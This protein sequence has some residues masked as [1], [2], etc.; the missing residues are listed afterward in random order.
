MNDVA[1][2]ELWPDLPLD[3]W[4]DTCRT[5]HLWTQIVGKVRIAQTP[6]I[7]H[8]WHVPLYLSARGLTTLVIPT[9]RGAL[10]LEFDL[11]NDRLEVRTSWGG[12]KSVALRAA[13]IADFH[14][15][16]METLKGFGLAIDIHG[17][18]N[19]LEDATPFAAD[20]RP[21][22]Y[23]AE[24]ARRFWRALISAERVFQRFRSSF[25]G[26]CSPIHFFWGSFDLAVTR[27]SGRTAPVHQGGIPNLPDWVAREA[28]S[29]EVSSAGFWPGGGPHPFPLFY[30]YAYPQ[31]DGFA[32]ADPGADQAFF[33]TELGEFVLPYEAVRAAD[34]PDGLLLHFLESTYRAAAEAASWDRPTLERHDPLPPAPR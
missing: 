8:S 3:A 6:W 5:F 7:N 25:I 29:H 26:K 31:P 17:S 13:P 14:G 18:P 2:E 21:R 12:E 22:S 16:L 27:F 4:E 33:S 9:D 24:Y 30:S 19:E 11:P 32:D 1:R 23:D 10:E 28:Y 34:D 15:E 20:T